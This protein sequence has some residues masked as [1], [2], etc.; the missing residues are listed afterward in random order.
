[1]T[2]PMLVIEQVA[3]NTV[4]HSAGLPPGAV[5]CSA[6]VAAIVVLPTFDTEN[7]ESEIVV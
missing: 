4:S 2:E 6:G 5:S 7:L 3:W 1:M